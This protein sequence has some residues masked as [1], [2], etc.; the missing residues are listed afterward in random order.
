MDKENKSVEIT[1]IFKYT[2]QK[3]GVLKNVLNQSER[4]VVYERQKRKK[5]D[6][7]TGTGSS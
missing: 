2:I 7:R 5:R 1:I 4:M 3:R 6:R